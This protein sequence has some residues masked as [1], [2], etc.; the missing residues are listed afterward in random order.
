MSVRKLLLCSAARARILALIQSN[1]EHIPSQSKSHLVLIQS[2]LHC[3]VIWNAFPSGIGIVVHPQHHLKM[4]L[5][6]IEPMCVLEMSNNH[7]FQF[8]Y[9]IP[10]KERQRLSIFELSLR[11]KQFSIL[12][13]NV[14]TNIRE[15]RCS[16]QCAP[17]HKGPWSSWGLLE[18]GRK[19]MKAIEK[20]R[21][22]HGLKPQASRPL[23]SP[24]TTTLSLAWSLN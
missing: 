14:H 16:R 17:P 9:H 12:N 21:L 7:P 20:L 1:T 22:R 24:S 2:F 4:S 10:Q 5:Q 18:A 23:G 15:E 19:C 11:K 8:I 6:K 13:W 3:V